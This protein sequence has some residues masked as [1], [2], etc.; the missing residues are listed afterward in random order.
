M[1]MLM[2]SGGRDDVPTVI[3]SGGLYEATTLVYGLEQNVHLN[4][5]CPIKALSLH[6]SL[7]LSAMCRGLGY[8]SPFS[9]LCLI[10]P[11]CRCPARIHELSLPALLHLCATVHITFRSWFCQSPLGCP[12]SF[13]L[14]CTVCV[15]RAHAIIYSRAYCLR[16]S[17]IWSYLGTLR[18]SP[19]FGSLGE[20]GC[21][22][23]SGSML[24][25]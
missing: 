20:R 18:V 19:S 8:V 9:C 2:L 14:N 6:L 1:A 21:H 22:H 11:Y 17:I 7:S 15:V 23:L 12:S 24:H 3:C 13:E 25:L 16:S 5:N 4:E 10:L